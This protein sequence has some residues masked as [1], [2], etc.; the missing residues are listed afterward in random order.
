MTQQEIVSAI[1][2]YARE[3]ARLT[4]TWPA[5]EPSKN[6]EAASDLL[7]LVIDFEGV[8]PGDHAIR[9]AERLGLKAPESVKEIVRE[10]YTSEPSDDR[11]SF[12]RWCK[13]SGEITD[14]SSGPSVVDGKTIY[15]KPLTERAWKCW[16]AARASVP[17][18]GNNQPSCEQV[19]TSLPPSV[20]QCIPMGPRPW[21]FCQLCGG[22]ITVTKEGT[23]N[24]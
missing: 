6:L 24:A 21:N 14:W 7:E 1:H 2:H 13:E 19:G 18:M 3:L 9:L 17:P 20:C 22:R 4:A 11:A 8:V 12:E 23:P 10:R 16:Q 15:L 5:D